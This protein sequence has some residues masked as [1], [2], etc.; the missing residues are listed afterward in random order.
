M[1]VAKTYEKCEI[2]GEVFTE[3]KRNYVM[4]KTAKGEKKVR[5]YSDTEY[6]RM[7]PDAPVQDI[8]MTFN[9]R[10]AFGFDDAGY[11]TV[12][13]GN[14]DTIQDW[15]HTAWPP[16]AW[17]N[18][19]FGFYT[20]SKIN[21]GAVPTGIQKVKLTWDEVKQ[22]DI[23]MKAHEDVRNYVNNLFG[24]AT[25]QTCKF[26]PDTWLEKEVE[27]KDKTAKESHFGEKRKFTL[28]DAENNTYVWETGAKDYQ[29]GMV[30]KL[31][32]KVKECKENATIVWY[33]KEI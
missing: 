29:V 33:C 18:E 30:V 15:A 7:Y 4:V 3:N 17:Y 24:V 16:K 9:A 22:D 10:H 6:R 20:P 21:P 13:H 5:W 32:M 11:I 14:H 2:L 31:K 12:Y 26:K 8:M 27:V 28:V 25:V 23:H 1:P 19:T